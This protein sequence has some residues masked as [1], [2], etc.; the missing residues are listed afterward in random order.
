MILLSVLG[1]LLL[2]SGMA[3]GLFLL[4]FLP[5]RFR[6]P[7]YGAAGS[8][9]G[10]LATSWISLL[11]IL[12]IG[13]R[14]GLPMAVVLSAAGAWATWRARR[15]WRAR[16]SPLRTR[17]D[18][19]VWI[20]V[21]LATGALLLHR[22]LS[23]MLAQKDGAYYCATNTWGDLALHLSLLTRF[24]YQQHFTWDFPIFYSGT[25]SY[26]FLLDFLSGV[27]HR[28]GWSLQAALIVPGFALAFSFLQL[29][30][31]TGYRW[32]RSSAAAAIAP[33]LFL[34]SGA[35]A[36][37]AV[38]WNDFRESGKPL[39]AFLASMDKMYG[40][41]PEQGLHFSNVVTDY[42]LP[43]RS[44]L[45]GL[46][47]FLLISVLLREAW[48]RERHAK[49]LLLT[50]GLLA[51]LLP[52]GHVHG[53]FTVMGLWA[54]LGILQSDRR[55]TLWNP[56]VRGWLLAL[57]IAA[58]QLA[59]QFHASYSGHFS[60]WEL[61][62]L[63]PE[64]Q[65]PLL[66]WVRNLGVALP[67]GALLLGWLWWRRR[68]H[69]FHFHYFF[70]LA[71]LFAIT[72]VY[73]FQPNM[74]DNMKFMVFSYLVLSIYLGYLF[75]RWIARSWTS[76]IAALV[77][78]LSLTLAGIL[79]IAY[80][81]RVSWLFSSEEDIAAAAAVR[82]DIPPEARVLT[83]DQHNHFL[84]TLTGRRIVLGYRGWL[85]SYG[86]NYSMVGRDVAAMYA[87]GDEAM[88]LFRRYDVS[89][90]CVGPSERA[91]LH[92]DEDFFRNRYPPVV[93]S[94]PY[95]IYYVRSRTP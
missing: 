4:R 78:I 1:A 17:R 67:L 52:F 93:E 86:V 95:T 38:F 35:P 74:F 47:L 44:I 73:R 19:V 22:F 61:W 39:L 28:L 55:R 32:F 69:A 71:A 85:W 24:S 56:W 94:G 50:A 49:T 29:L 41:V 80:D 7:E 11:C 13:Y 77:C 5:I 37:V 51:G 40:H 63:K 42:L 54:W 92:P 53:F 31:F 2:A 57:A 68:R 25:L 72:N 26:P 30:Y 12:L 9:V 8:V 45:F 43:Q 60:G 21:S 18:R 6:I 89:Y 3:L 34:A 36:G 62:W 27:L 90:V 87:G 20:F 66:F 59:W 33:L 16:I 76:G 10:L 83:S 84:P 81:T 48:T 64:D 14:W 65:S 15:Q 23:Q 88:R 91:Q 58:P 79:S 82:Q 70:A 46:P 75:A